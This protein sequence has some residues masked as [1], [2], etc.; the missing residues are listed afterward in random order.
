[1]VSELALLP[2]DRALRRWDL[3]AAVYTLRSAVGA[4][5]GWQIWPLAELHRGL[6]ELK[7]LGL[8][9]PAGWPDT[10]GGSEPDRG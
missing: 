7:R 1:M 9:P 3:A 8:R 2:S 4:A 5:A 6:L 10:G